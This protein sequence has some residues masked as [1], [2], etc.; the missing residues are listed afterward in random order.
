MRV[1]ITFK[2]KY[3]LFQLLVL[4]SYF[5]MLL[6]ILI[7]L[8]IKILYKNIFSNYLKILLGIENIPIMRD[9]QLCN[10]FN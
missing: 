2:L 6:E 7:L 4:K 9:Y 10:V 8:K 5:K 3:F 1:I